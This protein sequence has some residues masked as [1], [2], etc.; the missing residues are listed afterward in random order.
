[1]N[2][3]RKNESNELSILPKQDLFI[4]KPT[5]LEEALRYSEIIARAGIC[6]DSLRGKPNDIFCITQVGAEIGLSCFQSMR[7]LGCING[8]IFA[9][10]DGLFALTKRHPKYAGCKEW[11]E[12]SLEDGT[13]TAFT[14]I[15]TTDGYETTQSFSIEDAKLAKLWG[16]PGPWSLY[17]RRMLQWR[18]RGYASR[19]AIP[20][21]TYGIYTQDEAYNIEPVVQVKIKNESKGMEGLTKSLNIN[22]DNIEEAEIIDTKPLIDELK[23][24]IYLTETKEE[25]VQKYL[26]KK[27]VKTL[28]E[29]NTDQITNLINN[30]KSKLEKK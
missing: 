17:R 15:K 18:A 25:A 4:Y 6:P 11:F 16:K 12:G 10:G 26:D 24:L 3:V 21:A 19:D 30:L 2:V 13:L 1:M 8:R 7:A 14:M 27:N 28:E 23:G 22:D 5:S 29:L 9:Y 20:E